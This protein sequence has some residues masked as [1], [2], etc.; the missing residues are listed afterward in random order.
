MACIASWLMD[1]WLIVGLYCTLDDGLEA[2]R[3]LIMHPAVDWK[4]ISPDPATCVVR[5]GASCKM[6]DSIE[7]EIKMYTRV[8][9]T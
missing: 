6:E 5:P 9:L 1:W 4:C 8:Y 3:R 7:I 2:D